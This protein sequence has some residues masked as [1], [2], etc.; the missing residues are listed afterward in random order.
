MESRKT[1][2][3]ALAI[4]S[5]VSALTFLGIFIYVLVTVID[6][7][8]R[9]GS[10]GDVSGQVAAI[11]FV[12]VVILLFPAVF[13]SI[14]GSA[15]IRGGGRTVKPMPIGIWGGAS[16]VTG[17]TS[18]TFFIALPAA[19]N[20]FASASSVL[21]VLIILASVTT[22]AMGIAACA[23]ATAL[24]RHKAAGTLKELPAYSPAYAGPAQGPSPAEMLQK[25]ASLKAAG[26][27]TEAEYDQKRRDYLSKM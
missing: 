6:A 25:L 8:N 16:M 14:L 26:L 5:F 19:M 22:F 13:S 27:I 2:S 24:L 4:T 9:Y 12:Y 7:L 21:L 17:L 11:V 23:F 1:T 10:G 15:L 18:A 3:V 20:G